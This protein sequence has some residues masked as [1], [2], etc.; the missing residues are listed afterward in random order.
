MN[1]E[2][3][4][5]HPI[6][7]HILEVLGGVESARFISLRPPRTDTNLLTYH[8]KLLI[9]RGL[10]SKRS[11]RYYISQK[12]IYVSSITTKSGVSVLD[13]VLVRIGLVIQN[14]N[15]DILLEK[16][17]SQPYID[18][19]DLPSVTVS[20]KDKS[21]ERVI[22]GVMQDKLKVASVKAIHA[23]EAYVRVRSGKSIS[24]LTLTH[25]FKFYS[26]DIATSGTLEWA[27][28]HKL[29]RYH[30]APGT[31]S[32]ITRTFFNDPSFFEEFEEKLG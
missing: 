25:V 2:I 7:K 6:E 23:G 16:R 4:I 5:K 26:D 12:G 11:D 28:P 15:G 30:L 17:S 8:L 14:S 29:H 32:I 22:F 1:N 18:R 19:W 3:L 21:L 9:S 27:R 20:S 24:S 31:E 13:A 10:V